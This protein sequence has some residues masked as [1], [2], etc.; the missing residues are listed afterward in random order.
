MQKSLQTKFFKKKCRIIFIKNAEKFTK[1]FIS[2]IFKKKIRKFS[3]K[4]FIK[5]TYFGV[6]R[7]IAGREKCRAV[8]RICALS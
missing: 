7:A 4:K 8:E 5:Y 2:K 3:K 1:N 6:H